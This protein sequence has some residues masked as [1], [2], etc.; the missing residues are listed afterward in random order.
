[1]TF[2]ISAFPREAAGQP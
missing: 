2:S 1:M